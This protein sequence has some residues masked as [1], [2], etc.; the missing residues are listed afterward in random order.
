MVVTNPEEERQRK[1]RRI[2]PEGETGRARQRRWSTG[3]KE[4]KN[5]RSEETCLIVPYC[6]NYPIINND[7]LLEI[8]LENNDSTIESND[9]LI[10]NTIDSRIKRP[11]HETNIGIKR[12][13]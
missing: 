5:I 4:R 8:H 13:R 11:I 10:K 12:K 2:I 3:G 1:T 9:N 6:R 7:F